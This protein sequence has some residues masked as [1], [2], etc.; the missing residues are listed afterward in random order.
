MVVTVL[1]MHMA[2]GNF[3]RNARPLVNHCQAKAQRLTL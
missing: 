2:V 1:T 3:F